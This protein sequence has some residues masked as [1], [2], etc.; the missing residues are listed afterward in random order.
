MTTRRIAWAGPMIPVVDAHHHIWRQDDLPWLKGPMVPRIFGPYEPIRRDYPI[1]EYLADIADGR[2]EIRL[3]AGELARRSMPRTRWPGCRGPGQETRLAARDRRLRRPD[4]GGRA[5]GARPA[6]TISAL[7]RHPHAASLARERAIPLRQAPRP[8][9]RPDV[10]PEFRGARRLRALLRPAGLC[11]Q[12]EGAARL[13]ADF[14][15]TTFILQ[16][17]GML[18]DLSE[19]G[20]AVWRHACSVS[21]R[22]RTS[23]PS[24]PGSAPSSTRTTP[25]TS[26]GSCA[27]TVALFGAERCLFGSNF[28]IEKLWTGYPCAARCLSRCRR[29]LAGSRAARHPSRHRGEGAIDSR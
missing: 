27:E 5:P 6:K 16:H 17:A 4:G 8:R 24:S 20:R 1:E 10:P 19:A 2:R 14:P 23:S 28:P 26:P 3:R 15:K 22:S 9:R 7:A 11:D 21:R 18:E 12:M 13:A 29:R 25:S